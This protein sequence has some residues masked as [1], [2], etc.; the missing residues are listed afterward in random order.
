MLLLLS[1]EM[2]NSLTQT[3]GQAPAGQQTDEGDKWGQKELLKG[4]AES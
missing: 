3:A 4:L 1:C 2:R